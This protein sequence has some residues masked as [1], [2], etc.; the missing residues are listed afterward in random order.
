MCATEMCNWSKNEAM[1][2]AQNW[3]VAVDG[4]EVILSACD[5]MA[6]GCIEA[7]KAA[8]LEDQITIFSIDG[9]K[10]ASR[11]SRMAASRRPS[12]RMP[13]AMPWRP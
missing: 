5:D 3:C 6:L 10:A 13:K 4:L 12:S 2:A 7:V 8:G 11:R 9:L 1:T